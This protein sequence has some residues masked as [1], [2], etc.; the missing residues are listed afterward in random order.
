[1]GAFSKPLEQAKNNPASYTMV[2]PGTFWYKSECLEGATE[3]QLRT[4]IGVSMQLA[5]IR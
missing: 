2:Q 4:E 1:M 5:P 3:Q